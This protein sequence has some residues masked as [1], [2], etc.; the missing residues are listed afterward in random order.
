MIHQAAP[1]TR[2]ERITHRMLEK[3]AQAL[4]VVYSDSPYNDARVERRLT[5]TL[6]SGKLTATRGTG[7]A[8]ASHELENVLEVAYQNVITVTPRRVEA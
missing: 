3:N 6:E 1:S 8:V 5:L 7:H 4:E 2:V